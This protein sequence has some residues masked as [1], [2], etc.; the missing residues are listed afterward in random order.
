MYFYADKPSPPQDLKITGYSRDS[1]SVSWSAPASDGG[2]PIQSYIVERRDVKRN[3]WMTAGNTKP[4]Q[5]DLTVT[6]LMEGNEYLIRVFAENEV[7]ASEPVES[8]PVTA[9]M[10]FG[11]P[12]FSFC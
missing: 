10:P 8:E 3:T 1:I 4:E 6:K 11:E 7:G 9:K 12:T 5:L 2:S